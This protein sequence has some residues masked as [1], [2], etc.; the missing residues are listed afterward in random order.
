MNYLIFIPARGGSKGILNKNLRLLNGK[1]LISH[2]I[3]FAKK[4]NKFKKE[5]F[6]STDSKKIFK[7]AKKKGFKYNY[8]RP[9]SLSKSSSLMQF[10]II[11]AIKWLKKKHNKSF[12]GIIILQ[13]TSPIRILSELY[14]ATNFFEKKKIASLASVIKMKEHPYEC[15]EILNKQKNMWKYLSNNPLIYSPRQ[16]YKDNFYFIDGCFYILKTE[17]LL[18]KRKILCDKNTKIYISKNKFSIDIDEEED[19]MLADY[20]LRK[21]N[22]KN[23][24]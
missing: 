3:N 22:K 19:L 9:K 11:H 1:P 5:I 7:F 2:T 10:A 14:N 15:I 24:N 23:L 12:D 21:V 13:P 20:Y 8:L 17:F 4:I 16:T 18:K 6:I